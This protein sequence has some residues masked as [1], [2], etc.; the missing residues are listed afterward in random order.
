MNGI[1]ISIE[2]L[3]GSGKSTVATHI[4]KILSAKGQNITL[5][6]EPGTTNFGRQVREMLNY[7]DLNLC[8]KAE[9]LLFA[10]NRAQHFYETIIPQLKTG[11]IIVS[12]RMADSSI[13]YQG[14]GYGL[15]IDFIKQVNA[16]A[17]YNLK[18]HYTI[19]LKANPEIV[20]NRIKNRNAKLTNFET[21]GLDFFTKVSNGFDEIFQDQSNAFI[22][23]A[24]QTLEKVLLSIQDIIQKIICL[25]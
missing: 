3:D 13:A 12:D 2:G 5:T 16:Y 15:D 11:N 7:K 1:L 10:S 9:F 17:M 4:A 19:Y 22:V 14:F 20:F 23:D 24:T 25:Q 18:P 21:K 8:P 6:R